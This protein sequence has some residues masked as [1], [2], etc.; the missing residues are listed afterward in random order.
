MF[1][2]ICS[3]ILNYCAWHCKHRV[4]ENAIQRVESCVLPKLQAGVVLSSPQKV[5]KKW[6]LVLAESKMD[7]A[8]T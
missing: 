2:Q 5:K 3:F 7:T 8:N 6:V 1:I 4:S